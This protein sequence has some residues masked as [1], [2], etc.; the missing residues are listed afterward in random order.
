MRKSDIL[1]I[2]PTITE[3]GNDKITSLREK[4]KVWNNPGNYFDSIPKMTLGGKTSEFGTKDF[5]QTK[6]RGGGGS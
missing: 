4:A 2:G 3:S 5:L 1:Q 6:D